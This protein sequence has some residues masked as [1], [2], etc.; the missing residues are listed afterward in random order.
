MKRLND[1]IKYEFDNFMTKNPLS[2]I[3]GL[4]VLVIVIILIGTLL[5]TLLIRGDDLAILE[6]LQQAVADRLL[7]V[8]GHHPSGRPRDGQDSEADGKHPAH[9]ESL[10]SGSKEAARL[11]E[12]EP[13]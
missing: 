7:G 2:Q 9:A 1:K 13:N 10:Q 4:A 5:A 12:I 3:L 8:L 11:R 6:N